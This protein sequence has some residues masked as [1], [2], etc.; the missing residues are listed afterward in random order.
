MNKKT[1]SER[2]ICT[3]FITPSLLADGWN[4]NTHIRYFKTKAIQFEE[5]AQIIDWWHNRKENEVAWKVNVKDL[6]RGFDL[7]VKNPKT[8][9]E[10]R[11]MSVADCL[12]ELRNSNS[13]VG[14]ALAAIEKEYT[15]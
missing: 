2:D 6:K 5:F 15:R 14:E 4:L 12:V 13:R 9:V 3:K 8:S 11:E 1:L 7:D 10:E